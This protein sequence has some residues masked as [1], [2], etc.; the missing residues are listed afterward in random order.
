MAE[1]RPARDGVDY[2]SVAVPSGPDSGSGLRELIYGRPCLAT[3]LGAGLIVLITILA[4]VPAM[5][6][7]YIWDDDYY[8]TGN[9][10]LRSWEGLQRIW[11]DVMPNP[12]EYPLP[13][14]YPLTHTT[15]WLEYRLWGLNPA[16]YHTT[17]VLLHTCNALLIWLVL[18]KLEVPGSWL[19]AAIF[20]VHPLS[21]ETV[22]WV[23]ERKN[24]L[25]FFFFLCALYVYLRY[26]GVIK[27][28]APDPSPP[29]P[30]PLSD[31]PNQPDEQRSQEQTQI[32]WFTLPDDPQRLYWLAAVLFVCA[33]LS[34]TVAS[35]MP[36][37]ALLIIWW[38]RGGKLAAQSVLPLLP[39]FVVGAAMG[40]LTA[41][42]ERVRVGVAMRSED[43][44]YAATALGEFGARCIIA[45]KAAWF[46][47]G[48][49]LFPYPLLFN[50]APRWNIDPSNGAQYLWPLAA[51]AVVVALVLLR[52][53]IG[54][55][56]LVAVLC[57]GGTLF[58]ALGFVDVWPM[59]YSFVADHF[60]YLSTIYLIALAAALVVRYLTLEVVTGLASVVLIL[61]FGT[62]FSYSRVFENEKTLWENVLTRTEQKSW[63]AAN[64]YG[65]ML[66]KYLG[67][68]DNAERWF[69]KVLKL[70]PDHPEARLNL[71]KVAIGRGVRADRARAIMLARQAAA[72]QQSATRASVTAPSTL[73]STVPTTQEIA[74]HWDQAIAY[75][76]DAIRVQPNYVDAYG[77]LGRLYLALQRTE[78]AKA[79]FQKM[80][81]IYPRQ[82]AAHELLGT[83]A[84]EKGDHKSAIEHFAKAVE[85]DPASA[86]AHEM[87][88]TELLKIGQVAQGLVEWD[89]AIRLSPGDARVPTRFG[90]LLAS[91]GEYGRAITYF[92]QALA[93]DGRN[94]EAMRGLGVVAAH[95]GFPDE[96][97]KLFE[98]AL[99]IDPTFSK[100]AESLEA[101]RSGRLR[102]ATT[103]AT[104]RA[105][106]KPITTTSPASQ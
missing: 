53:R 31:T 86:N 36:A 29:A 64:N 76:K 25:S 28:K 100:A 51:L 17:N 3:A 75:L 58:P 7:G 46:Y 16:G 8:V 32:Q 11:F 99:K 62:T 97:R 79:Q 57:Y 12:A 21:V 83:I 80:L 61:L 84:M 47:V 95:T 92:R 71:A 33:L 93:I 18:R 66:L 30:A 14:Y 48:K 98:E 68:L 89:E 82:A 96:A 103:R 23:A 101:L 88:G 20:A 5:R 67:D 35:S 10:L 6:A 9:Q 38:K 37:V 90:A 73:P 45:G 69:N 54:L 91:N 59:R 52:K 85:I 104:T 106:T 63:M 4:Y 65:S 40:M 70:K 13:Q 2:A 105:T 56:P 74:A 43:W 41:H 50:Y 49:L 44:D 102:P 1:E 19:A 15:F 72:T 87:L 94:V 42:M 81:E 55:A 39:M 34:K 26:A 27:G 78:E 60:T 24:A 22:A 77:E